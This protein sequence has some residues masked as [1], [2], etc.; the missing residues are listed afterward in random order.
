MYQYVNQLS[1]ASNFLSRA[2]PLVCNS[3][4]V[5]QKKKTKPCCLRFEITDIRAS[6]T[7]ERALNNELTLVVLP[8]YFMFVLVASTQSYSILE[9]KQQESNRTI[10]T[11]VS[12]K[13]LEYVF[14]LQEMYTSEKKTLPSFNCVSAALAPERIGSSS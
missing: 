3:S 1:T 11:S 4:F 6:K 14:S 10:E 5:S 9:G 2:T 8:R 12:T 7:I 13:P